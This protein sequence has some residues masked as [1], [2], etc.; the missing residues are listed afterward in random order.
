MRFRAGFAV[1]AAAMMLATHPWPASADTSVQAAGSFTLNIP[2]LGACQGVAKVSVRVTGADWL[3]HSLIAGG[4]GSF[5]PTA[6]AGAFC[7]LQDLNFLYGNQ[8]PASP[9]HC[10]STPIGVTGTAEMPASIAVHGNVVTATAEGPDCVGNRIL[11]I[12]TVTLGPGTAHYSFQE[13]INTRPPE[14][15]FITGGGTLTRGV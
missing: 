5:T 7:A 8:K 9:R 15:P 2:G 1:V 14:P 10:Q 4:Q 13:W 3:F 12:H 6:P 11:I